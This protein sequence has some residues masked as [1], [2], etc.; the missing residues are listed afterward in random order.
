MDG[1]NWEVCWRVVYYP[2]L[3]FREGLFKSCV[4]MKRNL[5]LWQLLYLIVQTILFRVIAIIMTSQ[6]SLR[7][8]P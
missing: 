1:H 2:P 6:E 5:Q 4:Q 7:E 8:E 3:D